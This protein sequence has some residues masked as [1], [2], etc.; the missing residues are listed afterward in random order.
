MAK[1]KGNNNNN[2]VT[3]NNNSYDSDEGEWTSVP[4]KEEKNRERKEKKEVREHEKKKKRDQEQKEHDEKQKKIAELFSDSS[5][6]FS[7]KNRPTNYNPWNIL[8]DDASDGEVGV[9]QHSH[10]KRQLQ[11]QYE[12]PDNGYSF[13][14][15]KLTEI[16][17][18]E[19][20]LK[21]KQ[22]QKKQKQQQKQQQNQPQ[23]NERLAFAEALKTF[24]FDK[25]YELLKN[26]E[27]KFPSVVDIQVQYVSEF[28]ENHFGKVPS[29]Q[30]VYHQKLDYLS[31]FDEKFKKETI[32]FF[33]RKPIG[34]IIPTVIFLTNNI[35][36]ILRKDKG[37]MTTSGV[38]LEI[39]L[40]TILRYFPDALLKNAN[41]FKS[42]NLQSLKPNV[43]SLYLWLFYQ[44]INTNPSV[45]SS[46][47][48]QI[49]FP[50]LYKSKINSEQNLELFVKF[51]DLLLESKK[52]QKNGV[53]IEETVLDL[54]LDEFIN[55]LILHNVQP[56]AMKYSD[57]LF[58]VEKLFPNNK[59][60]PAYFLTLLNYCVTFDE[61]L[62][63]MLLSKV[64]DC[65]NLDKD[66]YSVIK[67]R[68]V[69]IIAQ[70][71]NLLLFI[72]LQWRT[73]EKSGIQLVN[74]SKSNIYDLALFSQNENNNLSN[75]YY[76]NN[77]NSVAITNNSN[78]K[79]KQQPAKHKSPSYDID[80][81]NLC[82]ATCDAAISSF[83]PSHILRN[84][85]IVLAPIV[86]AAFGYYSRDP[87][88]NKFNHELLQK[89]LCQ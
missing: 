16:R 32:S 25:Y 11:K 24:E 44:P 53:K 12:N 52:I 8:D 22:K 66:C 23:S 84:V 58:D 71:N 69:E 2:H 74:L 38:G 82:N 27:T 39:L 60:S 68:Y 36:S 42:L 3:T 59:V 7:I 70:V 48:L 72:L 26:V 57:F 49:I 45:S 34:N 65:L 41:H 15:G 75:K 5:K 30:T 87:I 51:S 19:K 14:P 78:K 29:D 86:I 43:V 28:L 1:K 64:I 17:E 79:G 18:K 81:V 37:S 10:P 46:L 88:C 77:T 89:Y 35:V 80:E 6:A 63:N 31:K 47:W 54:A 76:Q 21:L 73:L 56:V 33:E 50:A 40:Q 4:T 61:N 83:K 20:Q 67:G 13:N 62:R 85:S 9:E 55:A